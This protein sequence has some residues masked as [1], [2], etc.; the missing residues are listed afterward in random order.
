MTNHVTRLITEVINHGHFQLLDELLSP[1]YQ[2]RSGAL[3]LQGP[4]ELKHLLRSFREAFP[5][6]TIAIEEQLSQGE[7]TVT[8][9]RFTG[10]H[11]GSFHGLPPTGRAV[12]VDLV[13]F[14]TVHEGRITAE[15]EI[16]DERALFEQL[17][18][19]A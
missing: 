15:Y 14:S 6:L 11:R 1:T 3:Q 18:L 13:I 10:H 4:N 16:I 8:R 12:D 19:A 9:A 17:G 5:D 2:Y 7:R